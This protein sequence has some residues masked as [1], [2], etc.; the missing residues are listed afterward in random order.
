MLTFIF[1]RPATKKKRPEIT[2]IHSTQEPLDFF[3]TLE[4]R[5]PAQP[6]VINRLQFIRT[7]TLQETVSAA[8]II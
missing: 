7:A 1:A 6:S 8:D 4:T 3:F 5:T 2:I